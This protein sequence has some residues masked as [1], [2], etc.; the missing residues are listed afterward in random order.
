MRAGRHAYVSKSVN[1]HVGAYRPEIDI[2]C[3]LQ[4]ILYLVFGD[5]D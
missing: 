5:R 3:L 4:L 1:M 2:S